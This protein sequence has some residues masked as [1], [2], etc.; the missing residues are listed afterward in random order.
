MRSTRAR[1]SLMEGGRVT[2]GWAGRVSRR[3]WLVL[4]RLTPVANR[5]QCRRVSESDINDMMLSRTGKI[6]ARN[7]SSEPL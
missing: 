2:H 7:T 1:S 6:R 4:A 5:T 3:C